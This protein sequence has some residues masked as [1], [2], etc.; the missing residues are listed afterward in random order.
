M[1][2]VLGPDW[3]LE[4]WAR[5]GQPRQLCVAYSGGRDSTVLLHS[6]AWMARSCPDQ[7]PEIRAVH[8][9]HELQAGA[10]SWAKHCERQAA[11]WSV[12]IRVLAVQVE[13]D[14]NGLEDAA[15]RARYTAMTQQLAPD[16][17]LLTAHHQ[18]DQAET[19]L[20]H[21]FRGAGVKGLSAMPALR[22]RLGSR[23]WR[24]MLQVPDDVIDRYAT[25]QSLGWIDDP[26]NQ[27]PR[28]RRNWLRNRVLPQLRDT[29]PRLDQQLAQTAAQMAEA[30]RH[31]DILADRWLAPLLK[32]AGAGLCLQGLS[33]YPEDQQRLMLRRWLE[34]VSP[35]TDQLSRLQAELIH[36]GPDRQPELVLG[37]WS[38]RRF[39]RALWRVQELP[40]VHSGERERHEVMVGA[41][42]LPGGAGILT[43]GG[44]GAL[45]QG[46]S[47][48]FAVGGER[49]KPHDQ[50]HHRSLKQLHQGAGVPP[51]IR[52][53][54]PLLWRD[55]ELLSVGGYWN[56]AEFVELQRQGLAFRWKHALCAE[57]RKPLRNDNPETA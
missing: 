11:T 19:L 24:P 56:S 55:Q 52:E 47:W 41:H 50:A 9:N 29:Y 15:R 57:P 51:W 22:E 7:A 36:A 33:T 1:T 48:R 12:P 31:L 23:H 38:V 10:A 14:G 5:I 17:W 49:I 53:R 6:L 21:L 3:W 54:T 46:L 26:S 37:D 20:L 18:R 44:E 4:Q 35:S 2:A 39:G 42:A 28:F 40:P 8:I 34:S 30:Q 43:I 27:D 13:T 32:E 16:E 45:L 25:S